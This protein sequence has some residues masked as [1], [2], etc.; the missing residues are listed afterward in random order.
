MKFRDM[1]DMCLSLNFILFWI[2]QIS[3]LNAFRKMLECVL[4]TK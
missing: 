2:L 4:Y 1:F 3:T